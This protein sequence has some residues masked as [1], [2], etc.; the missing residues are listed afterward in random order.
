MDKH[1][2]HFNSYSIGDVLITPDG[3]G[4]FGRVVGLN[5]DKKM[6]AVQNN[7]KSKTT[8]YTPSELEDFNISK[9]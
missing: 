8:E 2:A 9:A 5:V 3:E 7:Q 1:I 4:V 6:I